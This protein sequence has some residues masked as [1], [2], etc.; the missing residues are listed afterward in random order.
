MAATLVSI[1]ET[2][3]PAARARLTAWSLMSLVA[4]VGPASAQPSSYRSVQLQHG[5]AI[6]VPEHWKVL[7]EASRQNLASAGE[8][9]AQNSG[10]GL[11]SG[12][13]H[14]VR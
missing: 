5:I 3:A 7:S 4:L 8:A 9:I 11:Q 13:K 14:Y 2:A 6:E 1:R 12:K 10:V